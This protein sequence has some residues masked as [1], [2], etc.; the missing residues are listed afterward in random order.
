MP[1]MKLKLKFT[2]KVTFGPSPGGLT[3][4]PRVALR[5]RLGLGFWPKPRPRRT[6]AL[7]LSNVVEVEAC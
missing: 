2:S 7:S 5:P 4:G 3:L 6:L 1:K